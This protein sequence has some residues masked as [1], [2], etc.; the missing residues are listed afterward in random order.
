MTPREPTLGHSLTGQLDQVIRFLRGNGEGQSLTGLVALGLALVV[1][2][3]AIIPD[4][5]PTLQ[6]AQSVMFQVPELGV[7]ALAMVVPLISAGLNLAI[8]ASANQ[9]ALL[10]AFLLVHL[11]PPGSDAA[12]TALA[13]TLALAVGLAHCL[14]I[15]LVTGWLVATMGVHPIL[16]TLGTM[17]VIDGVSIYL[18][19]GTVIAGFPDAFQWIG[20]GVVAGI[21]VPFLIFVAMVLVVATILTRTPFGIAVYMIGSNLPATSYSGIDTKRVLI[22]VYVLSS[23]LCFVA[24]CLMMARFNSASAGYAKSYLLITILAA[25][26]GGV[27]PNGGFG[28]IAGL[29][30]ALLVLQIIS[31]G[32]NQLGLSQHLTLVLWGA[33]LLAVMT[34]R[35]IP[36]PLL[37]RRR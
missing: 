34:A 15:G 6:T 33:T 29:T 19:R 32:L 5:F 17:S 24:A 37:R 10:M 35:A 1:L 36:W 7:L 22:R 11:A 30:V 16:V 21:P 18:T 9:C 23:A 12:L 31:S 3:S 14:I 13:I 4:R 8:I 20:N 28:R 26:L 27:D 25:V 2:F